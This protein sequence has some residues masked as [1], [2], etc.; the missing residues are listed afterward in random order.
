MEET[1]N[2][3]K[4]E[5]APDHPMAFFQNILTEVENYRKDLIKV[6]CVASINE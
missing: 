1:S 5:N 4:I 3:S 6:M 2:L